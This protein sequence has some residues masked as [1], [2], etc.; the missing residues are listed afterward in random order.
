MDNKDKKIPMEYVLVKCIS[1]DGERRILPAEID[2]DDVPMCGNCY[3]PMVVKG[4]VRRS[5]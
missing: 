2:P 1:C 4:A 3:L 5:T